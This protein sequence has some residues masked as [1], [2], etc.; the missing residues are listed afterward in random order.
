MLR[1]CVRAGIA[2]LAAVSLL[3]GPALAQNQAGGAPAAPV[4][5]SESPTAAGAQASPA[6]PAP[7]RKLDLRLDYS[8]AREWFPH[9]AGPYTPMR[10]EE[11]SLTNSPRI[12]Q[13]LQNGKL[14]L[15]LQDAISLALEN[16]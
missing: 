9:V 8:A 15:S 14:M 1:N 2:F 6:T 16:N 5:S 4:S 13:L 10:P 12:D 7:P 11:P 3:P